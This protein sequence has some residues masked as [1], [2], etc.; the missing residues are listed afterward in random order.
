[1]NSGQW[2]CCE[3]LCLSVF[4]KFQFPFVCLGALKI[5]PV[6]RTSSRC[7]TAERKR[8]SPGTGNMNPLGWFTPILYQRKHDSSE[9]CLEI[10]GGVVVVVVVVTGWVSEG[11][12]ADI[13]CDWPELSQRIQLNKESY[14]PSCQYPL[15]SNTGRVFLLERSFLQ[16]MIFQRVHIYA[17]SPFYTVSQLPNGQ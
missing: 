17:T 13:K 4:S 8:S 7:R 6:S 2:E 9:D 12:G 5:A 11:S 16:S 3:Y 14:Y 10:H 1:M 15:L